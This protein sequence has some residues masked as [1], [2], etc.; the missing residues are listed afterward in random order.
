MKD[1]EE[2]VNACW[3]YSV[4]CVPK[5]LSILSFIFV[6]ISN[7][8]GCMFLQLAQ[9]V[10]MNERIYVLH[11]IIIIKSEVP[12]FANHHCLGFG[13]ETMVC[14]VCLLYIHMKL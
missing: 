4:V 9:Y 13:H 12:T 6:A 5:M 14:A 10:L 11:L 1:L 7:I 3:V 8:W 2:C